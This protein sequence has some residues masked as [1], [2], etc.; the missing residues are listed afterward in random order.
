L[1]YRSARLP[2]PTDQRARA[3]APTAQGVA[4]VNLAIADVEACDR[5]F[6]APLDDAA[7]RAVHDGLA[8]L[9]R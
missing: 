7:R 9:R 5:A 6:F 4:L 8:R 1:T 2:H 3:L